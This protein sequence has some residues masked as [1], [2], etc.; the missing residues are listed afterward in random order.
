MVSS[1]RWALVVSIALGVVLS[2]V[3]IEVGLRLVG[4][5]I[6]EKQ[7]I[8]NPGLTFAP[9]EFRI[10]TLGE[11]TT[12]EF[13]AGRALFWP[14]QLEQRL[15]AAN[16]GRQFKVINLARGGTSSPLLVRKI[17]DQLPQLRPHLVISMMGVN[18]T[19]EFEFLHTGGWRSLRLVKLASWIYRG[20]AARK[21][22]G[23]TGPSLTD[24]DYDRI[25]NQVNEPLAVE[26]LR[27]RSDLDAARTA[28]AAIAAREAAHQS[29]VYVIGAKMVQRATA[30]GTGNQV[31]VGDPFH[32]SL[33][34][35][36]VE[37]AD[38]A[39]R[40][41]SVPERLRSTLLGVEL[42]CLD[43]DRVKARTRV[44]EALAEGFPLD[45][46]VSTM[47]GAVGVED[48]RELARLLKEKGYSRGSQPFLVTLANHRKLA[49]LLEAQHVAYA[50]MQYPTGS[51]KATV[52]LF[53]ADPRHEFVNLIQA[54]YA[55]YPEDQKVAPEY[56]QVVIIDNEDF[57]RV[58]NVANRDQYF[59]DTFTAYAGGRFGHTTP[60]GHAL[61]ADNAARAIV[62][63]WQ[64]ILKSVNGR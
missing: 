32:E 59:T 17:E 31:Q 58:V 5:S 41:G 37:L 55:A 1:R 13:S 14:A 42:H 10:V 22:G 27:T 9:N 11:S 53:T 56:E 3:A 38:Q 6:T 16:L 48:D 19:V 60:R 28:V 21:P 64:R 4:W 50:A 30:S 8:N 34:A 57:D 26:R 18:D 52:N 24:A 43:H 63:N 47:I 2:L 33:V 39:H 23:V 49:E 51:R 44:R 62:D 15:N 54:M 7:A 12:A 46:H 36:C 40:L 25:E 29:T 45:E 20:I 35:L 61:I